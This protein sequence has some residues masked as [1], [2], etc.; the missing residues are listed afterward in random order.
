MEQ[1]SLVWAELENAALEMVSFS[2]LLLGVCHA[3]V[4]MLTSCIVVLQRAPMG[5]APYLLTEQ[6][7][8]STPL[9]ASTFES[10]HVCDLRLYIVG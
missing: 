9:S 10:T 2:T 1:S 3:L 8:V 6:R 5:G 7:G 4:R